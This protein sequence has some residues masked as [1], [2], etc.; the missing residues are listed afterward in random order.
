M[1][2]QTI[3]PGF[4][5]FRTKLLKLGLAVTGNRSRHLWDITC[6]RSNQFYN[7]TASHCR[8]SMPLKI[9]STFCI[10]PKP[11]NLL[12]IKFMNHFKIYVL[13]LFLLSLWLL[14]YKISLKRLCQGCGLSLIL[15]PGFNVSSPSLYSAN[16]TLFHVMSMDNDENLTLNL[17]RPNTTKIKTPSSHRRILTPNTENTFICNTTRPKQS[18]IQHSNGLK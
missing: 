1:P 13:A 17:S 3:Q 2:L 18:S 15:V 6:L 10:T 12:P 4:T 5:I 8:N 16:T 9:S 11:K 14:T 7:A